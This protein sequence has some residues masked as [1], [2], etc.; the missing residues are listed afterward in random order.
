[1]G[2]VLVLLQLDTPCFIDIHGV[3]HFPEEKQ[4]WIG[5][6]EQKGWKEGLGGEQGE[7]LQLGYNFFKKKIKHLH[8][9]KLYF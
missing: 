7:K 9:K 6:W 8:T 2:R 3:L 4:E 1:M 5:R